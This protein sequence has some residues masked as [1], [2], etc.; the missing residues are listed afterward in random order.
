MSQFKERLMSFFSERKPTQ[1][2]AIAILGAQALSFIIYR[3]ELASAHET[4]R[5]FNPFGTYVV[6]GFYPFGTYVVDGRLIFALTLLILG[7]VA[8]IILPSLTVTILAISFVWSSFLDSTIASAVGGMDIW[9]ASSNLNLQLSRASD[10]LGNLNLLVFILILFTVGW[11]LTKTYRQRVITW[12]DTKGAEVSKNASDYEHTSPLAII[13]LV[14]AFIF[15]IG[16]LLLAAIAKRDIAL[17]RQKVGG[18]DLIVAANVISVTFL[19]LQSLV[20]IGWL[21]TVLDIIPTA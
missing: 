2:F 3:I 5:G 15:P 13:S 14:L 9:A 10:W 1:N 17:A 20:I 7:V 8:Y 18:V 19:I 16:G 6:D 21:N 12:I 11:V 4:V